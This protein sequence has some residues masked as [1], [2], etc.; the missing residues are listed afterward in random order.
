M[1]ILA[2]SVAQLAM[3]LSVSFRMRRAFCTSLVGLNNVCSSRC[4]RYPQIV[5]T[6]LFAVIRLR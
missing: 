4:L 3:F 6:D 2:K 5:A 1:R